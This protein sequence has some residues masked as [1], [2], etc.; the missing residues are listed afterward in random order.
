MTQKVKKLINTQYYVL[1]VGTLF[2]WSVFSIELYSW[3][4]EINCPVG[5]PV[6]TQNPFLTPCF[7]GA[8]FFLIAFILST[9][10]KK[11]VFK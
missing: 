10:I 6:N 7:G 11:G 4:K 5:C 9:K 8:T 2:A 3:L 1:L